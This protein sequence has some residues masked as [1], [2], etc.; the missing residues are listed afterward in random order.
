[1]PVS[2]FEMLPT[3]YMVVFEAKNIR[4]N[5]IMLRSRQCPRHKNNTEQTNGNGREMFSNISNKTIHPQKMMIQ[6][7]I[8]VYLCSVALLYTILNLFLAERR[9]SLSTSVTST[10]VNLRLSTWLTYLPMIDFGNPTTFCVVSEVLYPESSRRLSS[11]S[12]DHVFPCSVY[13][14][15]SVAN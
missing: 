7:S 5:L 8:T 12:H 15:R 13:R 14:W 11:S 9:L 4:Q 10:S 2:L 6:Q 1:M 3:E